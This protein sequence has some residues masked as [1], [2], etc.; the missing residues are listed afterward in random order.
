LSDTK[1]KAIKPLALLTPL[2][3]RPRIP[4][5]TFVPWKTMP[6]KG[7]ESV[8]WE[9]ID[10]RWIT[11]ELGHGEQSGLAIVR[12]SAGQTVFVDSFEAALDLAKNWRTV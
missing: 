10:G 4:T 5:G 3:P 9:C 8:R 11:I 2:R 12:S 6:P 7:A 1:L